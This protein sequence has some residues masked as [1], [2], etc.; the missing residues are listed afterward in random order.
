[1]GIIPYF[2]TKATG[3]AAIGYTLKNANFAAKVH[4]DMYATEKD[5]AETTKYFNNTLYLNDLDYM[6]NKIKQKSF[7]HELG[8][9]YKRTINSAI[10]YLKGLGSSIMSNIVL[11]GLGV[12]AFLFKTPII[13]KTKNQI[14]GKLSGLCAIGAGLII[15]KRFLESYFALGVPNPLRKE[16]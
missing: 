6:E 1:M 10:G 7:E 5:A 16:E 3:I 14:S 11:F 2:L 15:A 13:S 12:G 8:T 4:A 9:S